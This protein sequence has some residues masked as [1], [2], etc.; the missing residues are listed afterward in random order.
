MI[1]QWS[2]HWPTNDVFNP[3]NEVLGPIKKQK[4]WIYPNHCVHFLKNNN[5]AIWKSGEISQKIINFCKIPF[6]CKNSDQ[7]HCVHFL[8][9]NNWAIWKSGEICLRRYREISQKIINFCKIPFSCKNSDQSQL[10]KIIDKFEKLPILN[11]APLGTVH[12][13][14]RT[15]LEFIGEKN[16]VIMIRR[17]IRRTTTS[18]RWYKSFMLL[19][20]PI[21]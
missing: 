10:I 7:S 20:Y 13:D 8:K 6:S 12:R 14:N 17:T 15:Y 1:F 18:I 3:Y 11:I 16:I 4:K 21:C 5:W 2:V 9:N 19:N